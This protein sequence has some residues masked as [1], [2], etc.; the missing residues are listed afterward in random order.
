LYAYDDEGCF[1][2][3][4]VMTMVSKVGLNRRITSKVAFGLGLWG[5]AVR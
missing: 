1:A 4:D 2:G 5:Q 3:L